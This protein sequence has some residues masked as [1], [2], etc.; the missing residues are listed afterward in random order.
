MQAS[1]AEARL[2]AL[3]RAASTEVCLSASIITASSALD[4]LSTSNLAYSSLSN[5]SISAL[6]LAINLALDSSYLAALLCALSQMLTFWASILSL[7][8][9]SNLFISPLTPPDF[10]RGRRRRIPF[11]V[12]RMSPY[13]L[14]VFPPVIKSFIINP[15][16]F[17]SLPLHPSHPP[18]LSEVFLS[19]FIRP[20]SILPSCSSCTPQPRLSGAAF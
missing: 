18:S 8:L 15:P 12:C 1:L 9:L 17:L 20:Q 14:C 6:L 10:D 4:R 13:S 19:I 11:V 16:P 7:Y 3:T 2:S 5:R